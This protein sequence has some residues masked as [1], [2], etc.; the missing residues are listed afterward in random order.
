MAKKEEYLQEL[1]RQINGTH[2]RAD[3]EFQFYPGKTS[4][5][6]KNAARPGDPNAPY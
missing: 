6:T 4:N 1:H 5:T 3:G 2:N